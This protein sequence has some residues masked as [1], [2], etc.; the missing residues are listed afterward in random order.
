MDAFSCTVVRNGAFGKNISISYASF[1]KNL[2]IS[3]YNGH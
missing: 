2:R 1:N 3:G